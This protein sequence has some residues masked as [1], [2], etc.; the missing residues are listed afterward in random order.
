MKHTKY[1]I[2]ILIVLGC[3]NH[4]SKNNTLKVSENDT[5]INL[6]IKGT[7]KDFIIHKTTLGQISDLQNVLDKFSNKL[8][9]TSE[10]SFDITGEGIEDEYKTT[11]KQKNDGFLVTNTIKQNDSIIW[12]DSLTIN[13]DIWY[14]W[15]D[16]VFFQ[17][18]PYSQFYIAYKDFNSF[19]GEKFDTT[20][21][22]Y[23]NNKMI[24][25]NYIGYENDPAYWND[26]LGNFKGRVIYNLTYEDGGI[27]LWDKRQRK[28]IP[29]C[30]P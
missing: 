9:F 2:I 29:I 24:I 25:Q 27:Y 21:E 5:V 14:Y 20:T 16:S 1:F 22:L 28:F 11:I 17:L 30:E 4:D 13:D 26:Y 23:K 8:E 12:L 7:S 6:T 3:A 15:E 10:K 18:K 19:V